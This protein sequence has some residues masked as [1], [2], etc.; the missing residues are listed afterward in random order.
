MARAALDLVVASADGAP[1]ELVPVGER[2]PLDLRL[3]QRV[4]GRVVLRGGQ[5]RPRPGELDGRQD[6]RGRGAA[7]RDDERGDG[8]G[9]DRRERAGEAEPATAM[10]RARALAVVLDPLAQRERRRR[11]H[12]GGRDEL[13]PALGELAPRARVVVRGGGNGA[14]HA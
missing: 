14:C 4:V 8:R 12:D 13:T 6:A 10:A 1:L 9:G 5:R 3:Q 2:Q 7:E 11:L